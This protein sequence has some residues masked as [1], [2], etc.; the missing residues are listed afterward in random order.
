MAILITKDQEQQLS[1]LAQSMDRLSE[2]VGSLDFSKTE[3]LI[4]HQ[5]NYIMKSIKDFEDRLIAAMEK[6]PHG[7]SRESFENSIKEARNQ[8]IREVREST[9][10]SDG[11]K[12]NDKADVMLQLLNETIR[13]LKEQNQ[14]LKR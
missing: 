12:H 3:R 14:I 6:T 2:K 7:T 9:V 4:D 5:H 13:L 1:R 11:K 8:I 10:F